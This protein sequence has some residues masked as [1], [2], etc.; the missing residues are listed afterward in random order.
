MLPAMTAKLKICQTILQ[1]LG[2][3]AFEFD[4]TMLMDAILLARQGEV[5]TKL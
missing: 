3:E 4:T 2:I 5:H 1:H